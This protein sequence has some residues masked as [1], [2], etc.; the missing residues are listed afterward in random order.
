MRRYSRDKIIRGGMTKGT[1]QAIRLIRQ[2]VRSGNIKTDIYVTKEGDRLDHIAALRLGSS[3]Y[4][5]IL[6]ALSGIGWG[7]QVPPGIR[8]LI[9]TSLN[10]IKRIVG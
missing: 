9:P 1:N 2:A 7:L 6:A 10:T 8:I 3:K 4:W 5:W